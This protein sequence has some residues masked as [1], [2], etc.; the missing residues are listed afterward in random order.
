MI[1][2]GKYNELQIGRFEKQGAYLT[3]QASGSLLL[4]RQY[5]PEGA[6][7]GDKIFVFVYKD[8]EHRPIATTLTPKIILGGFGLLKVKSVNNHGAFMDWGLPKDLF[9][10]YDEQHAK[11]AVGEEHLV[12][13]YLDIETERLAGSTKLSRHVEREEL[14]IE[15]N[16]EVDLLVWTKTDLGTRVIINEKHLGLVYTNEIFQPLELG[17]ELK[18][19]IKHIR[20]D[21]QIDVSLQKL[22][23]AQVDDSS[24]QI[25]DALERN[26][27]VLPIT[28]KSEPEVIK[29]HLG[30]SKKTFKKAVGALYK[31]RLIILEEDR[32]RLVAI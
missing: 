24:K 10:P 30:M 29:N 28:D 1:R 26:D 18:G 19:Y 23:Y 9:I 17:Q 21:L 31:K 12:Y 32:I 11:L 7:E 4:P 20:P 5:V 15:E 3:D 14:T 6:Q 13:M 22:G 2:L 16:E 8:S 25:L 27:G